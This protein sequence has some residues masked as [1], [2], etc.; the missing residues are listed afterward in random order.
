MTQR[1]KVLRS[2]HIPNNTKIQRN[3]FHEGS[4]GNSR[5]SLRKRYWIHPRQIKAMGASNKERHE[6][7]QLKHGVYN[8]LDDWSGVDCCQRIVPFRVMELEIET[9]EE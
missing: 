6:V 7:Q 4:N 1:R 5:I 9:F 2:T 8:N 3:S